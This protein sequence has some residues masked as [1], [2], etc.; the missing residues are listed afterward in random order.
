MKIQHS[1][2]KSDVF[3]LIATL[4]FD[5]EVA[6]H[7]LPTRIELFRDTERRRFYR[8]R[9]WERELFHL[10]MTLPKSPKSKER[11]PQSDEELLVERT[12]ELSDKFDKFEAAS[13]KKAMKMFLDSLKKYLKKVAG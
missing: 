4:E 2:V 5:L 7:F 13:P 12:W 10:K 1:A 8:C 3:K 11:H 6:G 9:M